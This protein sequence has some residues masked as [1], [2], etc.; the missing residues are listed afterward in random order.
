M[1][2]LILMMLLSVASNSAMAEWVA[3]AEQDS[4]TPYVNPHTISKN[5]SKVT[6]WWLADFKEVKNVAG[7]T[8]LSS[9]AQGEFDCQE[10]NAR[11]LTY[12]W[13][14]GN[15]G[16]GNVVFANDNQ[17]EWKPVPP[18]TL[19]EVVWKFACGKK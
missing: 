2:K 17:Q 1:Q 12:R 15:M 7:I 10:E 19:I 8:Y 3:L 5:G 4:L 16:S 6:M 11:T 13:Y 14:S 9:E 18:D